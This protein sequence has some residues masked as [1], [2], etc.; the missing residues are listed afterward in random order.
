MKKKLKC[1]L[2]IKIFPIKALDSL[3]STVLLTREFSIMSFCPGVYYTHILGWIPNNPFQSTLDTLKSSG[4][5]FAFGIDTDFSC[6][7]HG[8]CIRNM[9]FGGHVSPCFDESD[10]CLLERPYFALALM[11]MSDEYVACLIAHWKPAISHTPARVVVDF[12]VAPEKY[13]PILFEV[14]Q[15]LFEYLWL[16]EEKDE[17][18]SDLKHQE[19]LNLTVNK[20]ILPPA[21]VSALEDGGYTS[22]SEDGT[23][24]LFKRLA[25]LDL[26]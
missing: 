22:A 2:L 21:S 9:M 18:F 12:V 11:D 26:K 4:L 6:P 17:I 10:L 5:E 24:T 13:T 14:T 7:G 15:A 20:S 8:Q 1:A 19:C 16:T 25:F 23:E 3:P